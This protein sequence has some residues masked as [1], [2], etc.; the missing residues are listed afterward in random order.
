MLKIMLFFSYII[1]PAILSQ[2]PFALMMFGTSDMMEMMLRFRETS[3][4][5]EQN[6]FP[7]ET[8][9]SPFWEI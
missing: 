2:L 9:V 8:F 5:V 1:F 7:A 4:L 3:L 6:S